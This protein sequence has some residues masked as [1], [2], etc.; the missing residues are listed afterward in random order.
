MRVPPA[1]SGPGVAG[2]GLRHRFLE[3]SP[4]EKNSKIIRRMKQPSALWSVP[5][6]GRR[7]EKEVVGFWQHNGGQNQVRP[8]HLGGCG[9]VR[10]TLDLV[11]SSAE[12]VDHIWQTLWPTPV[13][14]SFNIGLFTFE[15][16]GPLAFPSPSHLILKFGQATLTRTV[17]NAPA[18]VNFSTR[19]T[20]SR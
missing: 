19:K 16:K 11:L 2:H 3:D 14:Q 7:V 1:A 15:R 20:T 8:F 17:E 4:Q 13:F 12:W 5:G 9:E 10:N 6:F 18:N